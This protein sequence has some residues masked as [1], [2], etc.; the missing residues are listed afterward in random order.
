MALTAWKTYASG[1][2]ATAADRNTFERDNGKW[3]THE[4]TD[5]A[6]CCRVTHSSNQT[7]TD[8]TVVYM[9]FDT[10]DFDVGAMHDTATNNSRLTI[11]SGGGGFYLFGMYVS[12]NSVYSATA[13]VY[14]MLA[15]RLNGATVTAQHSDQ[16]GISGQNE[17]YTMVQ[18]SDVLVATDYMEAG[19]FQNQGSDG[20]IAT[21]TGLPLFWC[22]WM[23]E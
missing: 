17:R 4:A 12:I 6:P 15:L 2:N 3:L 1:D 9:A 19:F 22:A 8:N 21:G 13:T 23:G 5:G 14:L 10:E 7:A 18:L 20:T 16:G 11:P